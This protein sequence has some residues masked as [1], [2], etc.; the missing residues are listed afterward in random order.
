MDLKAIFV[1]L[2]LMLNMMLLFKRKKKWAKSKYRWI[3]SFIFFIFSLLI[4]ISDLAVDFQ[5]PIIV[6]WGLMTPFV[7]TLIDYMFQSFSFG[8]HNRDFYLWLRGSDEIDESKLSGG[9]HVKISDRIFSMALIF[10]VI[11][12]PF[13]GFLVFR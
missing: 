10:I 8:L 4:Y 13:A 11:F 1:I 3:L 6:I 12:L 7:F 5:I 9:K 2:P